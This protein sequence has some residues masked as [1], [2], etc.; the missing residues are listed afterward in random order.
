MSA[1]PQYDQ[2]LQ[3]VSQTLQC[4]HQTAGDNHQGPQLGGD[5]GEEGVD[6]PAGGEHEEERQGDGEQ[7][8]LDVPVESW[9]GEEDGVGE[10]EA[11]LEDAG[12]H[13][14]Y[15]NGHCSYPARHLQISETSLQA[16][17]EGD[18][19]LCCSRS[20]VRCSTC[21]VSVVM[22]QLLGLGEDNVGGGHDEER[23]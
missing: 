3:Q 20:Q 23:E 11:G 7:V 1:V 13:N 22:Q 5:D 8:S 18:H 21:R 6:H 14:K 2:I 16:Q 12:H 15:N 9:H 17:D 4:S 10:L 19:S